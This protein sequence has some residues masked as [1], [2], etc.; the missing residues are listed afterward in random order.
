MKKH[1]GED[2]HPSWQQG[3]I[4]RKWRDAA[5]VGWNEAKLEYGLTLTRGSKWSLP[6]K[7]N[8][9]GGDNQPRYVGLAPDWII[10][11]EWK[12]EHGGFLLVPNALL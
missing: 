6:E 12:K 4:S 11:K 7:D 1:G 9:A 8:D 10:V 5:G 2:G 3:K